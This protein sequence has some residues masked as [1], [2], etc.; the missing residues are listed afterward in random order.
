MLDLNLPTSN[1]LPP[2][3]RRTRSER[4]EATVRILRAGIATIEKGVATLTAAYASWRLRRDTVRQLETLP[5]RLLKDIG[6]PRSQIWAVASD[7]VNVAARN[8]VSAPAPR[9][10]IAANRNRSDTGRRMVVPAPVGCG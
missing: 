7:L 9:H 6:L 2:H 10:H 5:D 3:L 1:V 4:A 8:E